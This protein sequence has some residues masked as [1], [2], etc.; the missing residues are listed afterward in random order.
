MSYENF[1]HCWLAFN[2]KYVNMPHALCTKPPSFP[3]QTQKT[4]GKEQYW[5]Q[6]WLTTENED[7]KHHFHLIYIWSYLF[8]QKG[9]ASSLCCVFLNFITTFQ[10][11]ICRPG[12]VKINLSHILIHP[13][14]QFTLRRERHG[15]VLFFLFFFFCFSNSRCSDSFTRTSTNLVIKLMIM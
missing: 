5:D 3:K 6:N 11:L 4:K 9:M 15:C 14:S 2:S 12:E 13:S 7:S 10:G 8:H 1:N